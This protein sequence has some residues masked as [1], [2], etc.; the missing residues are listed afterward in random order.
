MLLAA[1]AVGDALLDEVDLFGLVASRGVS[2]SSGGCGGEDVALM[3]RYRLCDR[4]AVED[5]KSSSYSKRGSAPDD[6]LRNR[7]NVPHTLDP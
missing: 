7:S 1:R 5:N 3:N 2:I 4:R 6:Y